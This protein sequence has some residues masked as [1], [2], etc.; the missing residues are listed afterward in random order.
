MRA[1]KGIR[2]GDRGKLEKNLMVALAWLMAIANR[3]HINLEED[4]WNRF[5]ALCSYCG[6]APCVCKKE[7][8]IERKKIIVD[9]SDK[10]QNLKDM[11]VMFNTIY[12]PDGRS[13]ADAGVHLAEEMGEVSEAVHNFLGQHVQEQ[14]D[15][16]QLEMSDFFSC[17][18]GVANSAQIN[19]SESLEKMFYENCHV[20]HKAPCECSFDSVAS[21]K[22]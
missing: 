5:P 11:Q 13:L 20:C 8:V 4:V 3:L 22:T 12:P 1:L 18:C 17:V 15:E 21:L 6:S 19:I 10:P 7:K 16:V 14:F 2:K 9:D